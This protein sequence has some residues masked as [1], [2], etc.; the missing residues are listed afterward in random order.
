[1]FEGSYVA[2]IT[3]LS[4]NGSLDETALRG[5]VKWHIDQ[6]TD[7]LVPVG[8]TGESPTLTSD[9]HLRVAQIVIEEA[10]GK[11]PVIAGCGSNNTAEALE[12][13]QQ[14]YKL[15]ADAAL[16]VT[17]YY[18]R[19]GPEG[20]YR[21]FKALSLQNDL[22]IIVYNIPARTTVDISPETMARLATLDSIIGV[23]DSS[24]DLARPL[25]EQQRINKHFT[26][27]SGEDGT[28]VAHRAAG[29]HGCISVTANIAPGLCARMHQACTENDFQTAMSIQKRLMPLHEALFLEPSPAGIKY[30]CSRLGLCTERLRLPLVTLQD[31]TKERIDAALKHIGF[32][33]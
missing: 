17:G 13:H 33:L 22:P 21:H 4:A 6:G 2:M 25:M 10:K 29:G 26:S 27:L 12:F 23:K 18:N 5:L 1:M 16:H 3:P 7:G 28:A 9:E 14:A 15:G 30:A 19:P 11:L 8:T 20:I 31:A 24:T 32:D